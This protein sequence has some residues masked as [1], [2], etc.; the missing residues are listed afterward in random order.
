MKRTPILTVG[1]WFVSAMLAV[2]AGDS[3]QAAPAKSGGDLARQAEFPLTAKN[4]PW[5]VLVKS[6]KGPEAI[7]F[8]NQLA[9]ELRDEHR[10]QAYTFIIRADEWRNEMGHIT[11]GRV[12][13]ADSAAVLAGDCQNEKTARKLQKKIQEI[14]PKT[15]ATFE[16]EIPRYQREFGPLSTAMCLP[17]PMA[18]TSR[19]EEQTDSVFAK[20]TT[21][22]IAKWNSGK[23]SI[24]HCPGIYTLQAIAFTGAVAYDPEKFKEFE[25]SNLLAQA[26]VRAERVAETLRKQGIDAYTFHTQTASLVTVGAFGSQNDPQIAQV[27]KQIAGKVVGEFVIVNEPQLM[28]VPRK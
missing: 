14:R 23:Y 2:A 10:I 25:K 11:E 15:L 7:R 20:W 4:G 27:R 19:D 1:A 13:Q 18:P 28:E 26:E 17:N 5:M 8:A 21:A 24:F 22:D 12:R 3:R 9:R 16:V 6:F